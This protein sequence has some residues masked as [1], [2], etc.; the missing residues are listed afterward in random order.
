MKIGLDMGGTK[1]EIIAIDDAGKVL[2]RKRAPTPDSYIDT[3]NCLADLVEWGGTAGGP[4]RHR[5]PGHERQPRRSRPGQ[6]VGDLH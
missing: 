3:L 1:I 6:G 4:E 2:Y 5:W